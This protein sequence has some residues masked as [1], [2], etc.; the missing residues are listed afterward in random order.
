MPELRT[1]GQWLWSCEAC[2]TGLEGTRDIPLDSSP[3]ADSPSESTGISGTKEKSTVS[4]LP[5]RRVHRS[6]LR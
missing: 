6:V 3:G 1:S 2:D 4:P 5:L